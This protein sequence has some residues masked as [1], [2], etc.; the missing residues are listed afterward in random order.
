MYGGKKRYYYC[1]KNQKHKNRRFFKKD[2]KNLKS[3]KFIYQNIKKEKCIKTR[4]KRKKDQVHLAQT[5]FLQLLQKNKWITHAFATS[6]LLSTARS[7]YIQSPVGPIKVPLP[8][9]LKSGETIKIDSCTPGQGVIK[10]LGGYFCYQK[11]DVRIIDK[12]NKLLTRQ[13]TNIIDPNEKTCNPN[14]CPKFAINCKKGRKICNLESCIPC[15]K[16]YGFD[17]S[18]QN[19]DPEIC[20]YFENMTISTNQQQQELLS[21]K[22][23][24]QINAL[25]QKI[26]QLQFWTIAFVC[27]SLGLSIGTLFKITA[28]PI[29][30]FCLIKKLQKKKR[31]KNNKRKKNKKRIK[32]Y[33][34]P[35]ESTTSSDISTYSDNES[36][37]S[38]LTSS[39]ASTDT[40]L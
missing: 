39:F 32:K 17:S 19:I 34:S 5:K 15:Y 25:D 40:F 4:K 13:Y 29:Y 26:A 37:T 14:F 27:I 36:D 7:L 23:N 11:C 21:T 12:K 28:L 18:D 31:K 6:L 10:S 38:E 22:A 24:S 30:I 20:F 33:I 2:K 8:F 16:E 9:T 35:V 3:K 1:Q